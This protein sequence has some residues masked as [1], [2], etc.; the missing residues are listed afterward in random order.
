MKPKE[1]AI[2]QLVDKR[3]DDLLHDTSKM[4]D[5]ILN[6]KKRS[7][8]IDRLLIYNKD[9]G[10][11]WFTVDPDEIKAAAMNYFQNYAIPSSS[12]CPMSQKWKAQYRPKDYINAA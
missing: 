1:I 4:I 3:C 7:I 9:T 10:E 2:Q 8:V 11:K 12:V 6:W 5:S